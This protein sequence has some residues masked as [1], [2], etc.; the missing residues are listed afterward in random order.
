MISFDILLMGLM[1]VSTLTSLVTEAVK[2]VLVDRNVKYSANT[3]TGIV[4]MVLSLI[5][6]IGY[7][8]LTSTTFTAQ[9]IVYLIALMLISWLGAMIG[10][11]KVKQVIDQLKNVKKG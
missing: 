7:L 10:Y 11:D 3:L 1:A 6:G 8:V 2:K 9:V 5:I 4:A